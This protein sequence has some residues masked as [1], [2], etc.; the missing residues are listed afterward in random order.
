MKKI[1]KFAIILLFAGSFSCGN[2]NDSE[3]CEQC[4][5]ETGTMMLNPEPHLCDEYEYFIAI[6]STNTIPFKVYLPNN[7]PDE[8][9]SHNLSVQVTYRL[10]DE[11]QQCG[12]SGKTQ[13]INVIKIV[14]L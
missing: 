2:N 12:F 1:L 3:Q 6:P 7:L 9:K 4:I 14:K 13:V 11:I 5:T 10:T 8:F